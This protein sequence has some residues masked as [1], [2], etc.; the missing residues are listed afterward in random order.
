MT[1]RRRGVLPVPDGAL[2]WEAEGQGPPVVLLHGFTL[3]RRMW[4][5]QAASLADR[6]TVVRYDLRGH[7]AS[8]PPAGPYRHADDLLA[9]L[10][11]LDLERP[12]LV[13]LSL[14]GGVAGTFAA[15]HPDR[16]RALVLVESSLAG[17]AWSE[18]LQRAL[19]GVRDAAARGG[20]EAARAAWLAIPLLAAPLAHPECG[21]DLRGWLTGYSGWHWVHA[22][23]AL[24]ADPPTC[25]LL[26]RIRVPT[27]VVTGERTLP[28]FVKVAEVLCKGI[29]GARRAVVPGAAHLPN[30]EASGIFDALLLDFLRAEAVR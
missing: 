27:L 10:D 7:G 29:A 19:A 2:A 17:V 3:D 22:D 6:F 8:P 5:R 12:A 18:E 25:E 14:G 13:G 21:P 15:Q 4:N 28:D 16:L 24:P 20:V 30:L 1:T 9:L 26:H 11:G 23:P